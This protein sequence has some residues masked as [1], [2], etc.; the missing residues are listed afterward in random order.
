MTNYVFVKNRVVI[1]HKFSL[2]PTSTTIASSFCLLFLQLLK[3]GLD[4]HLDSFVFGA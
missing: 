3:Q 1:K 2:P 4:P